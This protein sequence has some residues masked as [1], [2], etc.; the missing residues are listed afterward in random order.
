[1][2]H[3]HLDPLGKVAD[4]LKRDKRSGT[5]AKDNCRLVCQM[6]DQAPHVIG[7]RREPVGVVLWSIKGTA[8][9][10]APII[11]DDLIV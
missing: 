10:P 6:L 8:R 4:D 9:K 2:G 7:I 11:G 1:M 5:V 3:H